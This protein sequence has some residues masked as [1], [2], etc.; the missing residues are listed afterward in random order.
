MPNDL[1]FPS[2]GAS[3]L[4]A[5]FTRRAVQKIVTVARSLRRDGWTERKI[6]ARMKEDLRAYPAHAVRRLYDLSREKA[7]PD[8]VRPSNLVSEQAVKERTLRLT[9]KVPVPGIE[10][11]GLLQHKGDCWYVVSASGP[12]YV[13]KSLA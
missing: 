3:T 9:V 12:T 4:A 6:L 1:L 8:D 13:I 5:Q 10:Q 11:G 7:V 2:E